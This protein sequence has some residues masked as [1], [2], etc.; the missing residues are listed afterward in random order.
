MRKEQG[1]SHR[2][3][4][5]RDEDNVSKALRAD[6]GGKQAVNVITTQQDHWTTSRPSS[7]PKEQHF[8]PE[9]A[10]DGMEERVSSTS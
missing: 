4:E 3:A 1:L 5:R 7:P 9:V 10:E 2:A 8:P 6:L